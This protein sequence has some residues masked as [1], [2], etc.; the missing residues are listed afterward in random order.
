[1]SIP[2]NTD[3][4]EFIRGSSE[5]PLSPMGRE[6]AID[7]AQRNAGKFNKIISSSLGRAKDTAA[8]LKATNPDAQVGVSDQLHPWRLGGH[9]GKPVEDVMPD[10]LDRI[11]NRPGENA[12]KGRGPLSTKDGESFSDFKDRSLNATKATLMSMKPGEKVAMVKHYRNIRADAAWLAAGAKPDNSID[13]QTMLEKGDS[14]P[15]DMFYMTPKGLQKTDVADQPGLYLIRH[16]A[17][18][19]NEEDKSAGS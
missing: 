12:P 4:K 5:V 7:L 6:Q 15:G 13:T 11:E 18:A 16:G 3:G 8:A 9:E 17:T 14:K 1:M 2:T 19:W 10:L